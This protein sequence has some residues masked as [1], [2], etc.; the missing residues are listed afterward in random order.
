MLQKCIFFNKDIFGKGHLRVLYKG[1][2]ASSYSSYSGISLCT[3]KRQLCNFKFLSLFITLFAK[4]AARSARCVGAPCRC[5]RI[6]GRGRHR[7]CR[8]HVG[9]GRSVLAVGGRAV[10]IIAGGKDGGE[11]AGAAH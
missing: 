6:R 2:E 8:R 4:Q 5:I 11:A 3:M 9:R 1:A 10:V 7:R